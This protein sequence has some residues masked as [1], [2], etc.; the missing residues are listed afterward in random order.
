MKNNL[1]EKTILEAIEQKIKTKQ[2]F[3]L[4]KREIFSSS[5]KT[6]PNYSSLLKEYRKLLKQ[7][8]IK[9]QENLEKILQTRKVR[10]LSG[11]A[12]VTVLTK[13]Y[14]C[15]GQCIYCPNDPTMP[16]SYIKTEPAAARALRLKFS[17]YKQV[18]LR[19]KAL[20][21]NGHPTDK[22]ELIV[23]GGTWSSYPMKYREEFIKKCFDAA[24]GKKSKTLE[25][26]QTINQTAKNRIIGLTL[27]T[28]P[29]WIN[30]K[31][32]QHL[33]RLGCTRL[34]LG[35]QTLENKVSR[36]ILRGHGQA[37]VA[38]ATKLLRDAGF[39]VDYHIMP[40]LPTATAKSDLEHFKIL[41]SDYHFRPDM[42][43]IY[44]C[45]VI[46]NTGLYKLWKDGKYKPL[47]AKELIEL[48]I[49]M[50]VEVPYYVRLSRVIRDIPGDEI[51]AGSEV[52]NL[53]EYIQREMD[54]RGLKCKCIRCREIGRSKIMKSKN[55]EIK[56]LFKQ[57]L[58]I[59]KYKASE[60]TEYF[61]SIEDPKRNTI[62]AF[63][64]LYLP[65][66]QDKELIKL[67]PTIEGS[68]FVR[69]LHTYGHLVPVAKKDKTASQHIGMGKKLMVE[70]EKIA[71][72][73]GFNKIAVISGVGVR[74]YY[75]KLNYRL[76]DT[77]MV[78]K[79]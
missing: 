5:K 51:A 55:H 21:L 54:N 49:K 67:L 35:V 75:K 74:D 2:S 28:R 79:I 62:F 4:L 58:F 15:P 72:K 47:E 16:K 3:D 14:P 41:F 42:I 48:L 6:Q 53:R 33:R 17:P 66:N 1:L 57:K 56:K 45:S 43:K 44:P 59:T 25:E 40:G 73:S 29:D 68:A 22:I 13:P 26:A 9:R 27:E 24:N 11:V 30:V 63:L 36:F 65:K 31:E 39:K 46:P 10:T 20:Q 23:K 50:K 52:T 32:I 18:Q 64:R 76:K 7:N 38:E 60:G 61:L 71:K 8:K 69:E 37:E 34:E 77:Y 12:V 19:I 70:A 78:K